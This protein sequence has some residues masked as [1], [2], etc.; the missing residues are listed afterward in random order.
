MRRVERMRQMKDGLLL[1]AA[2]LSVVF[3]VGCAEKKGPPAAL[4]PRE[5]EVLTLAPGQVRDTGEYL[6][7][8]LSRETV[9]VLPQI[10]GYVRK[11]HVKPGQRVAAGEPLIEVDSRQERAAVDS[12]KAQQESVKARLELARQTRARTEALYKEG[13][14]SAAELERTRADA[15]AAEAAARAAGAEVSQREVQ[16][17]YHV[18]RAAVPG[19]VGDVLVRVGD[20]VTG[21]TQLTSIAQADVLE[22]SVAVP[23]ARARS[24]QPGTPV[25]ILA[26][27]GSVLLHTRV[28]FIAPQ[29]DPQTQLVEVKA[30]FEN[31]A[32]L[33]PSEWVRT[34]LVFATQEAIQIPA[35]AVVR[36]SGQPFAFTVQDKDG[37][38]VVERR[39]I[40]LGALGDSSYVVTAGL[41]A[42]DRI[43]LTSLQM[44][45]DGAP[46]K[47][48][49]VTTPGSPEPRTASPTGGR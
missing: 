25:E 8:L 23:A 39:P 27:D 21:S 40:T 32:K 3:T 24:M 42:G 10:G 15:E 4:P 20:F 44:L 6:G 5:V 14:V 38:L 47:P 12:A 48:K 36:Q 33:R 41:K 37:K 1:S 30:V 31:S 43:A 35:T 13:L 45:R 17:Q 22:L 46:I 7:S 19:M 34:R 11:I 26:G 2:A 9:N 18:I 29:A 28:F 49:G 16:L